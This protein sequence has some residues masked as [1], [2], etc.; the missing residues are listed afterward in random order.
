MQKTLI[1][2]I[3]FCFQLGAEEAVIFESGDIEEIVPYVDE[4]SLL[5]LDLDNTVFCSATSLGSGAWFYDQLGKRIKEGFS[6]SEANLA[7]YPEWVRL[8]QVVEMQL[9]DERFPALIA[10]LQK[11]S[12][13]VLALTARHPIVAIP[14]LDQ[15][16][17]VGVD[18]S[19]HSFGERRFAAKY[20]TVFY[21]GVI[22]S[23]DLNDKGEILGQFLE[24]TEMRKSF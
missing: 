14:T 24:G 23:H 5:L 6:R 8:Q 12:K 9:V 15:L 19:A 22:F 4:K 17:S 21:D 16:A 18:F 10:K 1:F 7:L 3:L 11:Q 2:L 20:P 13:G